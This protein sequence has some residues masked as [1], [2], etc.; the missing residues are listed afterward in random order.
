[1]RSDLKFFVQGNIL[2]VV[3]CAFYLAWW[4]IAFKPEGAVKGMKSGWLLIPAAA[5]GILAV[6][7]TVKGI[8]NVNM[9]E[10][11]V[12]TLQIRVI[13]LVTYFILLIGTGLLMK[14]PV[15]T[16]LLLIVGWI[17]MVAAEIN[18]LGAADIFTRGETVSLVA[19]SLGLAVISLIC[20][21]AY[22]RLDA[23]KGYFD[24]M[25]PLIM[26]AVMSVM[27]L[28]AMR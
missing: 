10:A 27:L 15:T 6:Y 22:Y 21:L 5:A 3:C 16:E 25:V 24:G 18:A 17:T 19:I 26:A 23:V 28:V 7:K 2:L 14:R 8:S 12:S 9:A 13:G 11:S 4:L 1:M 20:Y